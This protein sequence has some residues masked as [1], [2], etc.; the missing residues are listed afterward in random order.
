MEVTFEI[1]I[2]ATSSLISFN[3]LKKS[4]NKNRKK[5]FKFQDYFLDLSKKLTFT[6]PLAIAQKEICF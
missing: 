5:T 6:T 4:L 3:Y 1:K 2:K